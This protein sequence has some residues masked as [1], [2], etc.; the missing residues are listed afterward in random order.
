MSGPK[1][2]AGR[3]SAIWVRK[4]V[5]VHIMPDELEMARLCEALWPG[6]RTSRLRV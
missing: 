2:G 4:R 1:H 6:A 3:S 5:V